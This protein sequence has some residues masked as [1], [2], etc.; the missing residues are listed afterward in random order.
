MPNIVIIH[1]MWS[2]PAV[3]DTLSAN[4]QKNGHK[5]FSPALRDYSE[6]TDHPDFGR[7]SISDYVTYVQR[8][9]EEQNFDT[10]P[11]LVGHSMGGLIAQILATRIQTTGIV[12]L[13]SAA[14]AGI[15][16]IF[17]SSLRSSINITST[18]GFWNRTHFPSFKRARYALFN[19][20]TDE[21]GKEIYQTLL[22]ESGRCFFEIVF[23]WLDPNKS[24][25]IEQAIDVP[26]LIVSGLQDRIVHPRVSKALA[27][28][29]PKATFCDFKKSGHWIFHEKGSEQIFAKV[30]HWIQTLDSHHGNPTVSVPLEK[31]AHQTPE[32]PARIRTDTSGTST[33]AAVE[34]NS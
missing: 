20:L 33:A 27:K 26:V 22:P 3:A 19:R 24:T 2:H 28:R 14:P 23:W 32:D 17:W 5:V 29:Y 13:N 21:K 4:L 30:S 34:Q 8:E 12:L 16:H 18:P 25:R 10:P 9:I 7:Q 6:G 15:N 11:L 1:G 31:R